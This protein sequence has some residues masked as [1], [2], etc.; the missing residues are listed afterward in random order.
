[1]GKKG[2]GSVKGKG[3]G[4][5]KTGHHGAGRMVKEDM[6]NE[7]PGR[8]RE[9]AEKGE[10]DPRNPA[11]RSKTVDDELRIFADTAADYMKSGGPNWQLCLQTKWTQ[12]VCLLTKLKW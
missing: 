6:R 7:G 4:K 8:E 9:R 3:K 10:G 11:A 5:G 1:M 12:N 2:K